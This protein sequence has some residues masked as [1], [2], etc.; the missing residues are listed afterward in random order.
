MLSNTSGERGRAGREIIRSKMK[1]CDRLLIIADQSLV[2]RSIL[3]N[4]VTAARALCWNHHNKH[5]WKQ[6][7]VET[8]LLRSLLK[9]VT[10]E[11]VIY[12]SAMCLVMG[13]QLLCMLLDSCKCHHPEVY[14]A[15]Y[16]LQ[17][18]ML[19]SRAQWTQLRHYSWGIRV[20]SYYRTEVVLV[21]MT[22]ES[23]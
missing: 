19:V 6:M 15:G 18:Q 8:V 7:L 5:S 1:S 2:S 9:S 20:A 13:N 23:S 21:G 11:H 12:T 22:P 10:R 16:S 4:Q 17:V 14:P 3:Y